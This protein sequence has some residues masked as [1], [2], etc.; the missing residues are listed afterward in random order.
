MLKQMDSVNEGEGTTLDN[1]NVYSG[2]EWTRG[3]AG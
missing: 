3:T 1:S 2:S